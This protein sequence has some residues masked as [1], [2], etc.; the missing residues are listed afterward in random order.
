MT[1]KERKE[2]R[3][4]VEPDEGRSCFG[5]PGRIRRTK[6]LCTMEVAAAGDG[7]TPHFKS[8]HAFEHDG[9]LFE[10]AGDG[11]L[12]QCVFGG[13][14]I[15]EQ[16]VPD[17]CG[18]TLFPR[19]GNVIAAVAN[20]LAA[21]QKIGNLHGGDDVTVL[22]GLLRA[23]MIARRENHEFRQAM[24]FEIERAKLGMVHAEDLVLDH[25]NGLRA[26]LGTAMNLREVIGETPGHDNLADV[27][28]EAGDVIGLIGGTGDVGGDFARHDGGADAVLPKFAPGEIA[29][30]GET[31]EILD[32]GRDHRELPDLP[33]PEVEDGFLD[34]VDGGV[35]TVVN[36][37]DQPQKARGKAGVAPDDFGDL[38]GVPR[39]GDEQA[40]ERLV[41]AAE[42]RQRRT[43][44][45]LRVNLIGTEPADGMLRRHLRGKIVIQL[46]PWYRRQTGR[47]ELESNNSA[48]RKNFPKGGRKCSDDTVA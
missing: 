20:A 29:L 6:A 17:R 15:R 44:R 45:E 40:L 11:G 25:R 10:R 7:R 38:R 35:K 24:A 36:G 26:G 12:G 2:H 9:D 30:P 39:F 43:P 1:A 41:D 37:V 16:Q 5:Q 18:E 19:D 27:M 34:A 28:N 21:Q 8:D 31:L 23:M 46:L 4:R 13:R 47:L 32:H 48:A 14:R 42:R 3:D 33:D 22:R